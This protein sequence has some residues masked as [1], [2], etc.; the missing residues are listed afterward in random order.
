MPR[1]PASSSSTLSLAGRLRSLGDAELTELLT[2]REFRDASLHDF[3]DLADALLDP[4]SVQKALVRL[5][6]QTLA[7]IG[8]VGGAEALGLT[9][10]A[11]GAAL[12]DGGQFGEG[13][14]RAS[15][16]RA[17]SLALIDRESEGADD[18]GWPTRPSPSSSRTGPSSASPASPRCSAIRRPPPSRR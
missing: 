10:A 12:A 9:T 16:D 2:V 3:F 11:V 8:V 4:A 17:H 1:V 13:S 6:R 15:L 14:A 7:A 5:D 18:A